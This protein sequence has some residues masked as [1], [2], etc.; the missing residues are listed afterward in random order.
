M[1]AVGGS[2]KLWF[3]GCLEMPLHLATWSASFLWQKEESQTLS[4]RVK[5]EQATE[6]VDTSCLYFSNFVALF[7]HPRSMA[8]S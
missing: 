2:E 3:M 5:Q 6:E 7:Q 1:N 8:L 4:I